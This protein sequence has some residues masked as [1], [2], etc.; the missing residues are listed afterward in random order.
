MSKPAIILFN[1]P[2][3]VL[4]QFTDT[5]GRSTLA[6]YIPLPDLYPAGRLDYDSEGLVLLTDAGW[7][8]HL[9]SHPKHKLTK[10]YWVQVEGIPDETALKHLRQ[11][12]DLKEGRTL[13]AGVRRIELPEVWP[14]NPPIR[15]RK[16]VPDSWLE[17]AITEGKNR[18][19][20]RMT[21]VIGYPTLRLIRV[22]IGPWELGSLKPGEWREVEAPASEQAYYRMIP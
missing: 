21:A 15:M 11:G 2:F 6:D 20:R 13:P 3:Q 10:V 22:A 18:Q 4:C 12:V 1:K 7:L 17:V 8:Q 16:T 9:I 5:S 14:R 19:V